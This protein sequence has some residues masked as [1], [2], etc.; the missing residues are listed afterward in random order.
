MVAKPVAARSVEDL[1][2]E[3]LKEIILSQRPPPADVEA[4]EEEDLGSP[5]DGPLTDMQETFCEAYVTCPNGAEAARRAGYLPRSARKQACRLLRKANI[6]KRIAELRV[7]LG[8]GNRIDRD[9]VMAKLE[10]LYCQA[11]EAGDR[12]VALRAAEAQARL[13]GLLSRRPAAADGPEQD[14]AAASEVP[15]RRRARAGRSRPV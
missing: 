13:A 1:T 6:L 11:M 7:D 4:C 3:E 8:A 10:T 2:D 14:A 5:E 15:P 9:T 12:R